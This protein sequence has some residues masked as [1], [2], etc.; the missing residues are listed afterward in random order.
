[1]SDELEKINPRVKVTTIGIRALREIPVYPLSVMEQLNLSNVISDA[2]AEFFAAK[3][4]LTTNKLELKTEN[5]EFVKMIIDILKTNI[6]RIIKLTT[7]EEGEDVLKEM[8]NDQ[9]ADYIDILY[10]DNYGKIV[11]KVTDLIQGLPEEKIPVEEILAKEAPAAP[12]TE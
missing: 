4:Q 11:K 12:E 9:L 1:M 7:D 10:Q 5:I 2:I 6:I 8:T 3:G